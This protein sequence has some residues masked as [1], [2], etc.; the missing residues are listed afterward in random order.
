MQ[1]RQFKF[2]FCLFYH[3]L[4]A[5]LC[6]SPPNCKLTPYQPSKKL[7]RP[8]EY[9]PDRLSLALEP[10]SAGLYC[11]NTREL[12]YNKPRRHFTVLDI[13]GGTLDITSYSIDDKRHICGVDKPDGDGCGGT[14]VNEAFAKFLATMVGDRDFT[15]YISEKDPQL[16]Q[17][18]KADLNKLIY[19]NFE[20]QKI[21]FGDTKGD[22]DG[23]P[24]EVDIPGSFL[25]FYGQKNLERTIELHYRRVADLD[26][27]K[28]TLEP[29]QMKQFFQPSIDCIC[30]KALLVLER[31]R[32]EVETLEIIYLVG[33]FGGCNL[34]MKVV[35]DC[36]QSKYLN[37]KVLVPNDH[38]MAVA[39]GAVIF[40]R[41]PEV[42]WAR[43]AEATYGDIVCARF[44]SE[45]HDHAYKTT[46]EHG[47]DFC[48]CLF[49][50]FTEKGDTICANEVLQNSVVPFS[51]KDTELVFDVYSSKDRGIYYAKDTARNLVPE[52]NR[53]GALVFD[54]KGIPG[55]SEYDKK[56]VL[57]I[58]ISQTEI[59]I[60]GHHE[61]SGKEVKVVLDT[62]TAFK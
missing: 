21:H 11:Q 40:R 55:E 51:S 32:K 25:K 17:Q 19:R 61:N 9:A 16:Q 2:A 15:N 18:H 23:V 44:D 13:G 53:I 27:G 43:K 1:Q 10:E 47:D 50:A 29:Q 48:S 34:I 4:Q 52:L 31:V 7:D 12:C 20:M 6:S 30:Q 39:C 58:D 41:N 35:E 5:G 56:I 3:V 24:A 42:I 62:L 60:K 8:I 14:Q 59:Q 22:G 36:L 26:M 38:L 57:T 28:L 33:G 45:K 49:R 46:D 54:L 37:I